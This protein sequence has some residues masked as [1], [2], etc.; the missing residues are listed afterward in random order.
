M[1]DDSL[2]K[3]VEEM[4]KE[5]GI[6]IFKISAATGEG[7]KELIAEISKLLKELP[8]EET[9]EATDERVVYTLKDDKEEFEIRKED[10]IYVVDGPAIQKIM[11]RA[12]LEDNESLYYFQKTLRNLGIEEALKAQGVQEGDTV[13]FNDWEL[14][15]F[16]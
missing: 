16:N 3:Q 1:Q 8:K 10:G 13:R 4:A 15:W 14:E 2:Y 7:V 11:S 6:K 12:N 5:K 9:I